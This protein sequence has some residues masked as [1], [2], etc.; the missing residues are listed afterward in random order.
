MSVYAKSVVI[1]VIKELVKHST[2]VTVTFTKAQFI[3]T[4]WRLRKERKIPSVKI[5]T[6]LR[7]LRKLAEESD[8]I[9]YRK[10]GVYEVDIISLP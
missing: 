8:L 10:K 6:L 3:T 1:A 2:E 4:Y 7:T 5:E 9:H